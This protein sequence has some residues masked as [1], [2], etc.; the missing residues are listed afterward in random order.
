MG[1]YYLART[2]LESVTTTNKRFQTPSLLVWAKTTSQP[3]QSSAY[4]QATMSTFLFTSESVNEGHPGT[5]SE[6]KFKRRWLDCFRGRT[7]RQPWRSMAVVAAISSER[8]D[9][10]VAVWICISAQYAETSLEFFF[11]L[12]NCCFSP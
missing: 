2:R 4:I 1:L 6:K 3:Y 9:R 12:T 8:V 7:R 10:T 11:C 5:F